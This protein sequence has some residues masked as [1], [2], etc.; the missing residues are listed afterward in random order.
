MYQEIHCNFWRFG[1][2]E[3]LL[4]AGCSSS[5]Q[6]W[7]WQMYI[8][9][10]HGRNMNMYVYIMDL[11]NSNSHCKK[12]HLAQLT[13][14]FATRDDT[15]QMGRIALDVIDQHADACLQQPF[16]CAILNL[17]D[18]KRRVTLCCWASLW[19][20]HPLQ[21][22]IHRMSI[23][24]SCQCTLAVCSIAKSSLK[25]AAGSSEPVLT[26][27][28]KTKSNWETLQILD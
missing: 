24:T 14:N 18:C 22:R 10:R 9:W 12:L 4:M 21:Q 16:A 2:M 25:C 8:A 3:G 11:W 5:V 20:R 19:P 6:W 27:L 26:A 17:L 13:P 7:H 28:R 1:N 23:A 15:I